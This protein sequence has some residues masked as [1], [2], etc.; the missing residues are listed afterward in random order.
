[1]NPRAVNY[2]ISLEEVLNGSFFEA[3]YSAACHGVFAK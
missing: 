1:M 2:K 3:E